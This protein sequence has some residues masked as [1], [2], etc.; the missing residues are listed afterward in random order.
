M[1][2]W[3]AFVKVVVLLAHVNARAAWVLT[4]DFVARYA[5]LV[6][7]WWAWA[8]WATLAAWLTTAA[9]PTAITVSIPGV[10][11]RL[12]RVGC[13]R[14]AAKVAVTTVLATSKITTCIHA[15]LRCATL[16][17]TT[18]RVTTSATTCTAARVAPCWLTS[19]AFAHARHHLATCCLGRSLHHVAARRFAQAAPN[20]LAAHGQR[21]GA[22]VRVG[23]KAGHAYH[24]NVLLGKAFNFLHEA[25]FV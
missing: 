1:A 7:V 19:T 25:F 3:L 15:V 24:F 13:A 17:A 23:F 20:G 5:W 11:P 10:L 21:L 16:A 9:I 18:A 14:A 12:T 4:L 2:G 8:L 22:F 6:A